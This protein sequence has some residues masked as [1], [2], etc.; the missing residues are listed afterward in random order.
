MDG[1]DLFGKISPFKGRGH[2][3]RCIVFRAFVVNASLC[4]CGLVNAQPVF[5]SV[6]LSSTTTSSPLVGGALSGSRK[7]GPQ[8]AAILT[9][10]STAVAPSVYTDTSLTS[11][12]KGEALKY[13]YYYEEIADREGPTWCGAAEAD[14][15]FAN[16]TDPVRSRIPYLLESCQPG[17]AW[18][19]SHGLPDGS[20][21]P[22]S[23]T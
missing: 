7:A 9:I 10:T 14:V 6:P 18:Y 19:Y 20:R 2:A 13:F 17:V 5:S 16:R 15:D 11:C 3:P 4:L 22:I 8:I 23:T 21:L 1:K 12:P